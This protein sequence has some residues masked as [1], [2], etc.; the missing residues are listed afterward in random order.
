MNSFFADDL[1][2]IFESASV[3]ELNE[4]IF[5]ST[6]ATVPILPSGA[7]TVQIT[8]T[9]GSGPERTHNSVLRPA[10]IR[11][12]AQILTR[13]ATP[14]LARAKAYE[15]YDAVVGLRNIIVYTTVVE[16]GTFYRE[17]NPLQEPFDVGV[18][19]RKQARYSFNVTAV[20]RP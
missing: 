3:G 17:I 6:K 11:P 4:D 14:A 9:S 8:E 2:E 1:V 19:D 13:A 10:Y 5:A 20:R 15:C 7:A 16:S 18:D 12:S